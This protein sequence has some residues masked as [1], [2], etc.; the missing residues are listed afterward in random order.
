MLRSK[1][2]KKRSREQGKRGTSG[3]VPRRRR[4]EE[5]DPG[6]IM[7]T[8]TLVAVALHSEV[9]ACDNTDNPGAKRRDSNISALRESVSYILI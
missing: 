8:M 1:R 5:T 6:G 4:S 3:T 7:R 9:W 2:K